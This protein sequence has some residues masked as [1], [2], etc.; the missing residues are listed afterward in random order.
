VNQEVVHQLHSG[1]AAVSGPCKPPGDVADSA[2]S[3]GY[4]LIGDLARD[5]GVTLRALRFYEDKGLLRPGRR[6]AVRLYSDRDRERLAI[7]L[8]GKQLGFTLGEIAGMIDRNEADFG[9]API[10]L[11]LRLSVDQICEQI[12][13]LEA[14]KRDIEAA[15]TELEASRTHVARLKL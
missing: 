14:Q 15:I 3:A 12:R 13:H 4:Y 5:F 11:T 9:A 7:I 8:K 1:H 10:G 6:G 2:I